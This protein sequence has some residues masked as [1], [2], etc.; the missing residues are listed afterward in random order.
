MESLDWQSVRPIVVV[1]EAV[2]LD[3]MLPAW[4]PWESM[5]LEAGYVFVWFDGLNRFY[6]RRESEEMKKHFVLPPGLVDDFV[7]DPGH[8]LCMPLRTRARLALK[9]NLPVGVYDFVMKVY[10]SLSHHRSLTEI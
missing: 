5:L 9:N 6:L 4:D 10:A 7:F 2:H 1:I 3:T 8:S